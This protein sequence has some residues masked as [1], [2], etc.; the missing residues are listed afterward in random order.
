MQGVESSDGFVVQRTG[1][2]T[3]EYCEGDRS[4]EISVETGVNGGR[5]VVSYRRS[6][7]HAW[8][9]D[10]SE[11]ARVIANYRKALEFMGSIPDEC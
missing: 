1:R 5:H 8:S 10:P 3:Q 6:D 2:F 11:Q 4:V 7:F 9:S